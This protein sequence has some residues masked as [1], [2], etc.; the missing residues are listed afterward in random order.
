MYH[1]YLPT[2]QSLIRWTVIPSCQ[3]QSSDTL[4]LRNGALSL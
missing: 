2:E 4:R 3:I 1:T